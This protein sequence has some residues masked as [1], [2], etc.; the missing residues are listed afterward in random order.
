MK[1]SKSRRVFP[2]RC[3]IVQA[4]ISAKRRR[5]IL[6]SALVVLAMFFLGPSALAKKN[7]GDWQVVE[8]LK[9]GTHVIVKAGHKYS[10]TVEGA[11]E[12]ELTCW[13]H[14][15]RSF[16]TITVVIP[17]GEI[18]EVRTL[19]NQAKDAWIGAGI[20][21]AAG[22]I[23]AG[24]TSR[25]YPGVNA[26]FGG[27]AGAGGGALVGAMVPIFQLIIQHGRVIYKQ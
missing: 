16:G 9:P 2:T 23:A 6:S 26:V 14:L 27:L 21:G 17:R 25:T 5:R 1:G 13:V 7:A 10:C 8:N 19:P 15:R 20:G 3:K 4:V 11:T 24:T 22:A 18:R 12:E